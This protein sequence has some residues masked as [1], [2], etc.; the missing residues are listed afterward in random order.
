MIRTMLPAVLG[1][2]AIL[3][4]TLYENLYIKDRWAKPGIEAAEMGKRFEQ[5]PLSIGDW[6]GEDLPVQEVIQ[7]T[8]GAV[9]YVSRRYVHTR[10]GKHVT[11]W[12]IVGHS[13]DI[14]RHTPNICYPAAGFR[15]VGSTLPHV[16]DL[17]DGKEARFFTAEYEKE[18]MT[19]RTTQRVFWT[20]N[21]PEKDQWDAPTD[22]ARW[23]Y[24]LS[25]ALYKMYFTSPV[26]SDDEIIEDSV[27]LDF[28]EEML[29]EIDKALFPNGPVA[30]ATTTSESA[31]DQ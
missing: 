7:Q 16:I 1:L 10:T 3:G 13:R 30:P 6:E 24:G 15:P 17:A 2:A 29:P 31:V 19:G 25:R 18:D 11:L 23:E 5:V 22:G 14:T 27:A 21:H 9:N 12:L 26:L 4:L 20:F 28:A 8:A